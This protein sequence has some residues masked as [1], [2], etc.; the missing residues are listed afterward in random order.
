MS[1]SRRL[2]ELEKFFEADDF[3]EPLPP[4]D[5]SA[6]GPSCVIHL[7]DNGRTFEGPL[8]TVRETRV[9]NGVLRIYPAGQC[10]TKPRDDPADWWKRSGSHNAKR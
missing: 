5:D 8:K 6:G 3:E 9:G 10:P 1:I 4:I 2:R 7:P